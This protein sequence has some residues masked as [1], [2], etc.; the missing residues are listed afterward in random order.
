MAG[1]NEAADLKHEA[2]TEEQTSLAFHKGFAMGISGER[3][4]SCTHPRVAG[5]VRSSRTSAPPCWGGVG[6]DFWPG[7]P[8]CP[9]STADSGAYNTL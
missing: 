2:R 8:C 7:P 1:V 4:P 6:S 9:A 5:G 3:W